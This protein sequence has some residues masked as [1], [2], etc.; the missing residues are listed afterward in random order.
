M[1]T[2]MYKSLC[3]RYLLYLTMVFSVTILQGCSSNPIA[4]QNQKTMLVSVPDSLLK[5]PCKA[6]APGNTVIDLGRAYN[7]NNSCIAKY[8]AQFKKLRE[9][10]LKQEKLY[11]N[12]ST[13]KP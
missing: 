6:V 10:K 1:L 4:T 7:A 9:H 11:D 8:K 2:Q 3:H 5:D 12:S 13:T